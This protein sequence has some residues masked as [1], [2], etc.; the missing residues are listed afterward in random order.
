MENSGF[1]F[2]ISYKWNISDAKFAVKGNATYLK[3]TLKNLG[4]DTGY[5]D[6]DGIQ[7]CPVVVRVGQTD[8]LFPYFFGY[9]TDGY[10]KIW[11]RSVL[12]S[13]RMGL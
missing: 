11:T 4:N 7:D 13:I 2:E 8:S 5:M 1:E 6:F 9:K 12:M 10:S 3:N